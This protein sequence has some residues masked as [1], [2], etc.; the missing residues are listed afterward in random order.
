MVSLLS[1]A[2]GKIG[3]DE[4]VRQA[5]AT[6]L[7]V[8]ASSSNLA[9]GFVAQQFGYDAGFLA[10]AGIAA[11]AFATLTLAMPETMR[12]AACPTLTT[13]STAISN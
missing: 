7:A 11:G 2:P 3:A 13:A 6:G 4:I 5:I 10:L 12:V 1:A 8:G 9:T